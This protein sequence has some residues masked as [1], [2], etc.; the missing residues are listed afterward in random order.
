MEALK[1]VVYNVFIFSL[2]II[3]AYYVSNYVLYGKTDIKYENIKSLVI[4]SNAS[5][6]IFGICVVVFLVT[7]LTIY[8]M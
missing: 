1:E 2:L 8:R 6:I 7:L 3:C 5:Y 4:L